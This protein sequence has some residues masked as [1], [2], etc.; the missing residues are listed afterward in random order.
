MT[1]PFQFDSVVKRASVATNTQQ[2]DTWSTGL[3]GCCGDRESCCEV[4][5]AQPFQ[6]ATQYN[7]LVYGRDA[8]HWPVCL[9]TFTLDVMGMVATCLP[10]GFGSAALTFELRQML[11]DRYGLAGSEA[12]DLIASLLCTE[13]S[14]CQNMREM[15]LRGDSPGSAC[16][17]NQAMRYDPLPCAPQ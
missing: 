2:G 11:R 7:L 15:K 3:L 6:Q 12:E 5:W 17:P 16:R 9:G 14:A 8:V 13:C 10:I 1:A 4:M